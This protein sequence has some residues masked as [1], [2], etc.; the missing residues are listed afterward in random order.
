M[1]SL[2]PP[3]Q[4]RLPVTN[5]CHTLFPHHRETV[6]IPES[7]AITAGCDPWLCHLGK[8]LS[9]ASVSSSKMEITSTCP[10]KVVLRVELMHSDQWWRMDNAI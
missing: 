7:R 9:C 8:S 10:H 4:I 5:S 3:D 2:I 6:I 1:S